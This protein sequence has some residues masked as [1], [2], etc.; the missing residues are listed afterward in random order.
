MEF[1]GDV[2]ALYFPPPEEK[3]FYEGDAAPFQK[4]MGRMHE[5]KTFHPSLTQD[6]KRLKLTARISLSENPHERLGTVRRFL[7][8]LTGW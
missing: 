7:E 4:I 8:K 5:L 2:L 6:K 1:E 3:E